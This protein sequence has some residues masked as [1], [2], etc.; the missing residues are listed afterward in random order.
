MLIFLF[1]P[2]KLDD[3]FY[4]RINSGTLD[5]SFT[6]NPA[7]GPIPVWNQLFT[8]PIRKFDSKIKFELLKYD[9]YK[10]NGKLN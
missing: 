9:Q 7:R 10:V 4:V 1:W 3:Q 2:I 8:L 6:T 5:Q